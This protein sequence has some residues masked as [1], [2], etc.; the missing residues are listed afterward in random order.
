MIL[1]A[2]VEK[3]YKIR[4]LGYRVLAIFIAKPITVI[5]IRNVGDD[6]GCAGHLQESAKNGGG[7]CAVDVIVAEYE[8]RF[9]VLDRGSQALS[10]SLHVDHDEW[11]W[12]M[13]DERSEEHTSELPSLLRLSYPVFCSKKNNYR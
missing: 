6:I 5:A 1:R 9:V 12:H 10:R 2:T 8:D 4:I 11:I 7:G 3:D 13:S